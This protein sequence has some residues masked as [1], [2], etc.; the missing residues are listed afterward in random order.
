[1]PRSP[2]RRVKPCELASRPVDPLPPTPAPALPPFSSTPDPVPSAR[3]RRRWFAFLIAASALLLVRC[4]TAPEPRRFDEVVAAGRPF[5][6]GTPVVLWKDE[7]GYDAYRLGKHF[8]TDEPLDGKP[9]YRK[10][11]ADLPEQLARD[12]ERRGWDLAELRSVV[13]LFVLHFDVAGTSRQCFKVLQ[14]VRSLSVH[15]LLDTDGTLYQTLDL[16][17][18]AHHATIANKC[19]I[20][21][22]I[23]HP[24]C[25]ARE[26]H[27]DMLRWYEQD[28]QGWR[29]KFPAFLGETG[30]RTKD[31]VP[32]PARNE[33]IS[34]PIHGVTY[35]Q[36]DFTEPQYR[37]LAGLCAALHRVF[38]RIRLDAPRDADGVV[39]TNQLTPEELFA[40]EGIVGH[41]HVQKNKTDPGPAFQWERVLR[42]ARALAE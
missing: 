34:G 32:R 3:R 13:H 4:A 10:V 41:Y 42:E 29:M 8:A 31:F 30:V 2:P 39:R 5:H 15:F 6:T 35:H 20:G 26:R 33:L 28:E 22:E 25:Y 11:R 37:A 1:M 23:A 38:P 12:V 27:P 18:Q 9:R 7:G 17:E 14:D 40:F 24:G 21:I 19:S 36:F 16:Q